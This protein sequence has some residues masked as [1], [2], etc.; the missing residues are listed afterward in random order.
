MDILANLAL[1]FETAL[2]PSTFA[3]VFI[4][5]LFGTFVGVLPG[6]GSL[7]GI[8]LLLPLTFSQTPTDG[9]VMLAGI[10]YGSQYGGS[11]AAI[12]LN[13]PGSASS[14]VACLD[15]YPMAKQG[16]AGIALC[17]TTVASFVGGCF[18]IVLMAAFAPPLVSVA[19]SFGSPEYFAMM[20]LGLVAAS[21]LSSGSPVKGLAMVVAGLII[22][23]V[24]IDVNSGTARYTFGIIELLDGVSMV[25]VAMGLFGVSEI[26]I[27][28]TQA[29][30]TSGEA[31]KV[32][33]RSLIPTR[34]DVMDSIGPIARGSLVGAFIGVLPGAGAT[35]ASYLSYSVEKRVAKDPSQFGKGAIQGLVASESADNS[36]AQAAFIPTMALGIPGS[37]A[38]ALILGALLIHGIVPGPMVM[39]QQ[40]EMF[41]GLIASFWIGNLVLLILNL[42]MIGIW[43]KLLLIPYRVLYPTILFFVCIGA[44]SVRNNP[45]DIFAVLF[46]GFVGYFMRLLGLPAAPLLM[47]FILGPLMEE[48]LRRALLISRGEIS[49]LFTQPVAASFLALSAIFILYS[50]FVSYRRRRAA[51]LL[52]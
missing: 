51:L 40:P 24:G 37:P 7:A 28:F 16:R 19:L 4:G 9:L 44:F 31:I 5:V 34:K 35:I 39:A 42:P 11:T 3:A 52:K 12:L 50:L 23:L 15:G 17:M 30:K 36:S 41:W 46:F 14:A 48:H 43:V 8:S 22:G 13:L 32:T 6:I 27:N 10:Y 26:F 29:S 18:S 33:W 20:L 45:F 1:G 2:S 21:T 25:V 49:V 38:M 47:G